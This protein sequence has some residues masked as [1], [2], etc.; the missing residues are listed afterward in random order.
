[1]KKLN[2]WM[3][4]T[5]LFCGLTLT[6]CK[7][8]D[9]VFSNVPAKDVWTELSQYMDTSVNPG[10]DFFMYCNG[11]WWKNTTVPVNVL[12]PGAEIV[13]YTND[14]A[15]IFQEK[16]DALTLPTMTKF[17]ADFDKMDQTEVHINVIHSAVGGV[18]VTKPASSRASPVAGLKRLLPPSNVVLIFAA[19]AGR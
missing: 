3:L 13:G 10:D 6:S 8:D 7:D 14:Y 16:V 2:L 17:N 4:A 9:D 19:F 15:R 12:L 1:M 11:T 18:T 5:I